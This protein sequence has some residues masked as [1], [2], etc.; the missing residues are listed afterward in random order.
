MFNLKKYA[1]SI[2]QVSSV[3]IIEDDRMVSTLLK[4][5]L[6][7]SGF[8][9]HQVFRGDHAQDAMG[10]FQPDVVVLDLNLPGL[11]G[12]HVCHQI[13]SYFKGPIVVLTAS[14]IETEQI[15]AFNLGADDYL[16]KPISPA[17]LQVRI[18]SLLRRQPIQS[19]NVIA[20]MFR[21]GDVALYP[22]ANKCQVNGK[23]IRLSSFEFKLLALLLRNV[24]RVMT[25]DSIYNLLLGREYNGIERTVDVRI[26]KLRDKLTTEGMKKTKIETVWGRGYVLNE[27]AA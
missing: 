12:F 19:N 27:I 10:R 1:E 22:E 4:A 5:S 17:I 8:I 11:D 26:S 18:E 20:K 25:R 21:V 3:L 6:E 16:V 23:G 14:D 7:K 2:E 15:T 9:A 24:G 13:R